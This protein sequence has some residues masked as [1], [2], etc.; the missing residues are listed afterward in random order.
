MGL[1]SLGLKLMNKKILFDTGRK[2]ETVLNNA[3]ELGIDLSDV[4]DVFL[5]HNHGDHTG[6][7]L[8]L[9]Q[10]LKKQN[11][12]AI[13]RIH[14]GAGIFA[15]RIALKKEMYL[16]AKGADS[17]SQ[18]KPAL[19]LMLEK[20]NDTHGRVFHN[21]QYL[22]YYSGEKKEHRKNIDWD[23]YTEIQSVQVYEFKAAI[24]EDSIGYVRIV[25]LP[26]GDN[27]KMSTDI[28]NAVCDLVE[29]G[30]KE[31]IIDLRYNGGGNMFPMVEGL[32]S[33]IG[34]GIVGGTKGVTKEESSVWQIKKGDFFYD[35]QNVAIE[36]TCPISEMQNVAVLTS[37]YTASS[38]E[39]LALVITKDRT[40]NIY[41]EYVDVDEVVAF[42]PKAEMENDNGINKAIEWL[43]ELNYEESERNVEQLDQLMDGEK[44]FLD[45]DLTLSKTSER[46]GISTKLLSQAINQVHKKNY[47]QYIANYRVEEAKRL[48]K[49]KEYANYKISAIA[50]DSGFNSISSFNTT[51]KKQTQIT[52]IEYRQSLKP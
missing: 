33:I 46:L 11:S 4:E 22:S 1:F 44:L 12:N 49:S 5:S 52:A 25:G 42:E 38:G 3:E 39:A 35:E 21:N 48:L 37:V 36:N 43:K 29:K 27:Q 31:W 8:T 45:P 9:R 30:A 24:L 20:L 40:N 7:L 47:S 50:Y 23:V 34:D 16:L 18:L 32:T 26:M 13:S 10:R 19:D 14:V 17:V 41:D 2:F 15:Q 51:F 28:Q 6:G